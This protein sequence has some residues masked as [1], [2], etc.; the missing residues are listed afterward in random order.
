MSHGLRRLP[1]NK[2]PDFSGRPMRSLGRRCERAA[3]LIVIALAY[4]RLQSEIGHWQALLAVAPLA[5]F[6]GSLGGVVIRQGRRRA[7]RMSSAE[8]P[9]LWVSPMSEIT[10]ATPAIGKSQHC[11]LFAADIAKFTDPRRDDEVRL[12]L[13]EALYSLLNAAFDHSGIPWG[14]CIHEDRGDGVVVV[15]PA[16]MPT[17]TV[18][19]VL[20]E[21]I[22]ARLCRHNRLSNAQAQVR[23]RLAVH[24][25]EVHR[26]GH[27]LVGE[28][29]NDLFRILDAEILREALRTSDMP[30]AL[31]VSDYFYKS[32]VRGA[33]GNI[34]AS[35][36]SEVTVSV[37]Q[38]HAS[39]WILMP[40]AGPPEAGGRSIIS[41]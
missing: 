39:A 10:P 2:V 12:A 37:K 7:R 31:I 38:F 24:I 20:I 40:S 29:V 15:I 25:G 27:G 8:R 3:L 9:A 18:A 11:V 14:C 41:R 35:A 17:I 32:V 34:Y 1:R 6:E 22:R 26:D 23:L 33:P 28:A 19:S 21:Q 36:Y 5:L 16:S 30:L 13:R 4:P